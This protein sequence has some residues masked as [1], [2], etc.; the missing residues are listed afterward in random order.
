MVLQS[1]S[2]NGVQKLTVTN[3]TLEKAM[4]LAARHNCVPLPYAQVANHLYL[5]DIVIVATGS[6]VPLITREMV[7]LSS[8]NRN[9]EKQVFVDISVP[10]NIEQDV[11]NI[12]TVTLFTIDDLKSVVN[13]NMEKRKESV[14]TAS[15][16]IKE[17]VA[18]YCE[19]LASRSLRPTIKTITNNMTKITKGELSEY[20]TVNSEEIQK[21]INDFSKHLTQKYTRLFIKNLK[22]ITANG[23]NGASLEI[24]NGLFSMEDK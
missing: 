7:E 22:E 4:K 18:D 21:A 23:K 24:V 10:R 11:E 8:N 3:R 1:L 2:K 19:W 14:S 9:G 20:N 17:I 5:Y 13:T 16:I 15:E 12:D 6:T